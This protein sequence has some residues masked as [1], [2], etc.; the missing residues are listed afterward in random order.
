MCGALLIHVIHLSHGLIPQHQAEWH[1]GPDEMPAHLMS[2]SAE[3]PWGHAAGPSL[4][5]GVASGY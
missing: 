2:D 4:I 3:F 5:L 1:T